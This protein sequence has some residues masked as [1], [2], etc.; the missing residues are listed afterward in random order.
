MVRQQADVVITGAF[1]GILWFLP[2]SVGPFLVGRAVDQGITGGSTEALL[3]WCLLLLLIVL[4]G[5]VFGIVMHTFAVRSWLIA[6]Y[7]TTK[8]VTRK[9]TQMGHVMPQ[10]APT[11]EILSVSSGDSDQFG[12]LMECLSRAAAA[13]MAYLLVAAIVL[14]TS[15]QLGLV[16]L[17]AAPILVGLAMPLLK[18]LQR[19]Q[20]TERT[21]SADLT[22]MATDIVAGLRILRGI[23][24]EHTFGRNYADQSQKVR[25]AGVSAGT[26]QALVDAIGVLFSGLFLVALTWLG[27]RQVIAG[28]LTVGQLISF[29]GYALFMV[30]PIQ[31]FFE[32]AQKW[33]RC[34]V[35]AHKTIAVMEHQPPWREE[36]EPKP[37]P[38]AAP[39]VDEKSGF[40][41]SPGRLTLVVSALPDDSAALADRLGR[42]LPADTDPVSAEL[43]EGIKGRAARQAR[44]E[45]QQ[46]RARRAAR[47][48]EI[49][50]GRWGVRVGDVDLAEATMADVRR[51][52]MVS[53][54][55]SLVFAGTLQSALD[56]HQVLTRSQAEQVLHVAAAEDV[57][58]AMPGGWQGRIDER[59]RGL[60]GGQRQ[61]LVLARAL[62]TD[63]EILVLVEPTSAVDAHTEAM[64]AERLAAHRRGRTTIVMSVSPLLLH[65]ADDVAFLQDGHVVAQGRHEDLLR[66]NRDYRRVVARNMEE[67]DV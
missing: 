2:G 31:T 28:T 4:V 46:A 11:G 7:R 62:A 65:Y 55:A 13:L 32:L 23:G 12:A 20:A 63:P 21:R 14:S 22:S 24:G 52:I 67:I 18:P 51:H 40:A 37:L 56:P 38:L 44:A 8:L 5:G 64:I 27:A 17:V 1:V 41:A 19:R 60:S 54:T 6:L 59:G 26:W 47:D 58:E 49:A 25:H 61:R 10:R 29:F 45:R 50:H 30:W 42:Y 16:V 53:D 66:N 9:T 48:L 34:L 39:I 36:R 57:F 43:D 35:S 3:K 33:V 15:V